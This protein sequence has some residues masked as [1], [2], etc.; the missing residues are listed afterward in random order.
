MFIKT[1]IKVLADFAVCDWWRYC[2]TLCDL[3]FSQIYGLNI[4]LHRAKQQR[5]HLNFP[6]VYCTL[7]GVFPYWVPECITKSVKLWNFRFHKEILWGVNLIL[8]YFWTC[9]D[10]GIFNSS[11]I[12][13]IIFMLNTVQSVFNSSQQTYTFCNIYN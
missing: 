12:T 7:A 3:K 9:L 10:E 6:T 1:V 4:W 8:I 2:K 11:W 5:H 13:F